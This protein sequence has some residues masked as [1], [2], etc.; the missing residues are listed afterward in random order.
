MIDDG[1][2]TTSLTLRSVRFFIPALYGEVFTQ[3]Y[4]ALYTYLDT[5]LMSL[6]GTQTLRLLS[7]RNICH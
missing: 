6:V 2:E 5:M 3:I 1:I 4:K 7:K